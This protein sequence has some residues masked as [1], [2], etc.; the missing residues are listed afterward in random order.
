[1]S[2]FG[3]WSAQAL[4]GAAEKSVARIGDADLGSA[5]AQQAQSM[6]APQRAALV[7]AVFEAFR[8]RGESSQDAAEDAGTTLERIE[9]GD[10][11]AMRLILDYAAASP[12]LLKE[13]TMLFVERRPD[14]I[15]ALPPLVTGAMMQRLSEGAAQ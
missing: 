2:V 1:M 8:D 14:H 3:K 6:D 15:E 13:A 10:R 9:A 7:D 5:Y 4:A 11:D 12:G